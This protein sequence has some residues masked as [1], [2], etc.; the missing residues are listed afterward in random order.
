[1]RIAALL[2]N[3]IIAARCYREN[4]QRAAK[5]SFLS[6]FSK[7]RLRSSAHQ[8]RTLRSNKKSHF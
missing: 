3:K 1:M 6:H 2:R 8:Q 7:V 4:K 5:R